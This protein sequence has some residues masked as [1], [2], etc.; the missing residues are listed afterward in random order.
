LAMMRRP[1]L[2]ALCALIG[3]GRMG[4]PEAPAPDARAVAG[5]AANNGSNRAQ[6]VC[7]GCIL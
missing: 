5:V 7:C 4:M 3:C 2:V 1:R 6:S